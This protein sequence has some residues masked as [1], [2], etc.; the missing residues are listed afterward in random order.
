MG[1][2]YTLKVR[3]MKRERE[4]QKEGMKGYSIRAAFITE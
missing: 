4:T 1:Q 3:I 2:R